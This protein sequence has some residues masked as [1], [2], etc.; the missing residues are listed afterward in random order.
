MKPFYLFFFLVFTATLPSFSQD[1]KAKDTILITGSAMGGMRFFQHGENLRMGQLTEIMKPN[2]E[3]YSYLQKA[4]TNN[5]FAL[6]FSAIG[7]FA[8]GW[9]LGSS[10]GGKS[11]DWGVM[12]GGIGAAGLSIPFGIA[13]KRNISKAVR[14]YNVSL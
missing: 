3:A 8:I 12:G 1:A 5:A 11:I 10:L 9:E 14:I 13:T 7:G 6:I 4:K 2:P